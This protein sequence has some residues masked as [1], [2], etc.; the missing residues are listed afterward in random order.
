MD[1]ISSRILKDA[2]KHLHK[3]F[4]HLYNIS[5]DHSS[6]PD[7][8]KIATVIPIPKVSN[9]DNPN[10]LRPISLLPIPGKILEALVH[11]QLYTHIES[12]NLL[13]NRQYGFRKNISTSMAL[14]TLLDDLALNLNDNTPP[15]PDCSIHWPQKGLWHTEPWNPSQQTHITRHCR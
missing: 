3:E 12:N 6:F 7:D 9:P 4:T 10:E 14:A 5:V 11:D 8:W 2:M 15:P 1:T 13:N